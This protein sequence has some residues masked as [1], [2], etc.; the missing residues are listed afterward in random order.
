MNAVKGVQFSIKRDHWEIKAVWRFNGRKTTIDMVQINH[1]FRQKTMTMADF[2]DRTGDLFTHDYGS[3]Y[4][5][6]Y[7]MK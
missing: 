7:L 5:A 4:S 6:K 1:P 3:F 2:Y